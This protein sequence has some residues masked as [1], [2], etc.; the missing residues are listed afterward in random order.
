MKMEKHY[1]I[2]IYKDGKLPY[3][4]Y[5]SSKGIIGIEKILIHWIEISKFRMNDP[6]KTTNAA[7]DCV[8]SITR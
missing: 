8:D 4:R 1:K 6:E 7:S 5:S 2:Y 3:F